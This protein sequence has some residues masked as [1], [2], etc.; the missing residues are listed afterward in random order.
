VDILLIEPNDGDCVLIEH[1]LSA[2]L[3]GVR[4]EIVRDAVSFG[5]IQNF[6]RF[7]LVI[8]CWR[9]PWTTARTVIRLVKG[10]SPGCPVV[11][12]SDPMPFLLDF[13]DIVRSSGADRYASKSPAMEKVCEVVS[14]ILA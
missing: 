10:E 8:T 13:S 4:L 12:V 3:P 1:A 7:A 9:L 14:A 6:E 2:A 11:V 5:A